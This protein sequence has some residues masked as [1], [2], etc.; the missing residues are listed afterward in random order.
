MLRVGIRVRVGQI[1]VVL[2]VGWP[3]VHETGMNVI[4]LSGFQRGEVRVDDRVDGLPD[5]V[6]EQVSAGQGETG[7]SMGMARS[8]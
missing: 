3:A 1:V 8:R 4:S 7:A 5:M 6:D 2:R